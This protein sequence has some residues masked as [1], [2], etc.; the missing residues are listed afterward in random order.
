MNVFRRALRDRVV[1]PLA[2]EVLPLHQRGDGQRDLAIGGGGLGRPGRKQLLSCRRRPGRPRPDTRRGD[3]S[4]RK[5]DGSMCV[6]FG[7]LGCPHAVPGRMLH[8]CLLKIRG[9]LDAAKAAETAGARPIG[10]S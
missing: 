7:S 3:T 2:R 1:E 9:Q 8:G 10:L 4:R 6:M 5:G